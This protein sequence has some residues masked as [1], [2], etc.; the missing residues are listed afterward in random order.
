MTEVIRMAHRSTASV[1]GAALALA[2]RNGVG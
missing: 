2:V 1:A